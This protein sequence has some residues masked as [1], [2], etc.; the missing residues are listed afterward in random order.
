MTYVPLI[1]KEYCAAPFV[2]LAKAFYSVDHFILLDRLRD[3]R[4]SELSGLAQELLLWPHTLSEGLYLMVSH[5]GAFWV[6]RY[7]I[8]TLI[9]LDLP[10]VTL[11]YIYMLMMPLF[12]HL[13]N[14]CIVCITGQL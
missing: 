3:I 12:I 10:L 4:L 8:F 9:T 14:Y 7:S 11:I 13:P 1:E 5:K 6:L 2:D